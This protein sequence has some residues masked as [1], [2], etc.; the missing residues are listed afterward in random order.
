MDNFNILVESLYENMLHDYV[1]IKGFL[2]IVKSW[3]SIYCK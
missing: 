1:V 3:F 2:F